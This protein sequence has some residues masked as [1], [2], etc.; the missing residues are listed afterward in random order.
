MNLN[1]NDSNL[2]KL[3]EISLKED[4]VTKDITTKLVFNGLDVNAKAEIY[5]KDTFVLCGIS[6][7][8][9][10]IETS[11]FNIEITV[12]KKDGDLV[13]PGD[14]LCELSGKGS[15][16]LSL[17]RTFLNFLQRLSSIATSTREFVEIAPDITVYDTRK[18]TP[19][20]RLLE[21]YAT[22]V[23]GATNHRFDLESQ[24]LLKNNH[25]DLVDST[26][27]EVLKK[28]VADKSDRIKLEVEVRDMEELT[29]TLNFPVD[30][31]MLDN[32]NNEQ[33]REAIKIIKENNSDILIEISGGIDSKRMLELKELGV[34]AV[35]TSKLITQAKGV[36]ISMKIYR[37][38]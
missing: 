11:G 5:S 4:K 22:K 24:I 8:P 25:I 36:D 14:K 32:F 16:L 34:K 6:L 10:I 12:L 31:I 35:S 15:D 23:G 38:S 28:I 7:I 1:L 2:R 33:I 27:A 17:E 21:K 3:V 9:L 30:I 37:E 20:Y 18:T 13:N 26:L 29:T 19:G